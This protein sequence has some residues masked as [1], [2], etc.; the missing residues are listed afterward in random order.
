MA[1][2][3]LNLALRF[4]LELAALGAMAYWGWTQHTGSERWLW[5]IIL[6][7][8]A[9]LL[10][11]T[12]RVPGDPGYA[13]IA[14]HGIVRLLLEAVFFGGAIWLLFAAGRN[15]WGTALLGVTLIHYA[16]SY[17]RILW[18]LRQ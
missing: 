8:L 17:D 3:P 5:T 13:P 10:W 18:M 15:G 11:G 4:I 1:N 12:V 6:P 7:L 2:H 16:L 9:A 14:V